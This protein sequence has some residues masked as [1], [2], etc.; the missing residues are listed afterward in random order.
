[1]EN[2]FFNGIQNDSVLICIDLGI[3]GMFVSKKRMSILLYVVYD[4]VYN[5]TKTPVL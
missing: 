1:M 4:L 2:H 3:F 5:L